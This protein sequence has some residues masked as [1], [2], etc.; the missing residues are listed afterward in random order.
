VWVREG[1]AEYERGTWDPNDLAAVREAV[2][3]N[4]VPAM[5]RLQG[6]EGGSPQLIA[7][8]GHAVF[9]FIESRAGKAG[10]RQFLFELR[11][12][13]DTGA[14]PFKAALQ[15]DRDAFD[16]AF[17][18]YLRQRLAAAANQEP[19]VFGDFDANLRVEGSVTAIRWP[20]A[21]GLACIELWVPIG[22]GIR[23]QRWALQCAADA[24]QKITAALKPGD[25]VIV[26]GRLARGITDQRLTLE[27]LTRPA[28]GFA[29]GAE[30][31]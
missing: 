21:D 24:G 16:R 20:V 27:S 23:R 30:S 15:M 31:K 3:S 5:S 13:A 12:T 19:P 6:G 28:D 22:D 18:V 9:D 14:D 29:W 2:R 26:T 11:M 1:L 4:A 25:H 8:F 10:V 17:E 7:G